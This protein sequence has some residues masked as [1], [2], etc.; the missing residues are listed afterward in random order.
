MAPALKNLVGGILVG[1]TGFL[2]KILPENTKLIKPIYGRAA[3]NPMITEAVK[4]DP[5]VYKG[6]VNLATTAFLV[7]TMDASPQTFSQYKCPFL[8][9]QG[10]CDKLVNPMV[11]FELFE[12]SQTAEKDK[13]IIFY[14]NMWHDI[15][16]E[17]EINEII[18]SIVNWIDGRLMSKENPYKT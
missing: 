17:P 13:Q 10:G 8:V 4:T 2:K 18:G 14:Q 7:S 16:H 5:Y 6:R 3:R 11:A 15:W 12:R 1:M 9:I